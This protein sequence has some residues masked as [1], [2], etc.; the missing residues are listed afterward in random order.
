MVRLLQRLPTQC[1]VCDQWPVASSIC[2]DCVQTHGAPL[3]PRRC[4]T[5][6]LALPLGVETSAGAQCAD[7]LRH[8]PPLAACWAA[9]DYASPWAAVIARWKLAQQPSLVHALAQHMAAALPNAA[10]VQQADVLLP[11]PP[12][13]ER[14]RWRGF[15]HTKML[16]QAWLAAQPATAATANSLCLEPHWLQRL[17]TPPENPLPQAQRGRAQRLRAM[18]NAFVVPP[19]ALHAVQGARVLLLDDVMTTGA[20]L[21]SAARCLQAAGAASVSAVVLARTPRV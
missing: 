7:C 10:I 2:S 17:P 13:P 5:C 3:G 12:A 16:A 20:T 15:H 6:A 21:Y 19:A 14:A 8:P 11:I 1:V 9:L 4:R 18:Q